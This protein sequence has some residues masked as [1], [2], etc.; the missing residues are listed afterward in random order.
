MGVV[1]GANTDVVV[2]FAALISKK[3][4]RAGTRN[5]GVMDDTPFHTSYINIVRNNGLAL[6]AGPS[7]PPA[8]MAATTTHKS[9]QA[10]RCM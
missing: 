5:S 2:V 10:M 4:E 1:F 9:G 3:P 8:M 6:P 7:D